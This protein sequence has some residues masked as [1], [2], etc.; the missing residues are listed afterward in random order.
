MISHHVVRLASTVSAATML[1]AIASCASQPTTNTVGLPMCDANNT[2]ITQFWVTIRLR[3]KVDDVF[4]PNIRSEPNVIYSVLPAP[5]AR[6]SGKE[7]DTKGQHL[8]SPFLDVDK[9]PYDSDLHLLSGVKPNDLVGFRVILDNNSQNTGDNSPNYLYYQE[10]NASGNGDDIR[11]VAVI[12]RSR[13]KFVCSR[14][15]PG[16]TDASDGKTKDM[17]YFYI[18]YRQAPQTPAYDSFSI[19]LVPKAGATTTVV[20]I[21]PKIMNSG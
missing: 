4:D 2:P 14:L 13:S 9:N 10:K 6:P 3:H 18:A 21:D 12:P 11:G 8:S 16:E 7:I 17:V 15:S 19:F 1:C 5:T 20:I